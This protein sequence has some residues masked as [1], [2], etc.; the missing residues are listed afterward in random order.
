[1]YNGKPKRKNDTK[2]KNPAY[3]LSGYSIWV[4]LVIMV[5]VAWVVIVMLALLGSVPE[6]IFSNIVIHYE[7]GG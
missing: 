3:Q 7:P 4:Y 5:I 1:M 6:N 2:S